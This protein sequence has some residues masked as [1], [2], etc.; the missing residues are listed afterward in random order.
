MLYCGCFRIRSRLSAFVF[1][2]W[3]QTFSMA[4]LTGTFRRRQVVLW[5][6]QVDCWRREQVSSAVFE[7]QCRLLKLDD[8]TAQRCLCPYNN[9]EY[10]VRMYNGASVLW[11]PDKA[12]F[13]VKKQERFH[14][15]FFD[16]PL[17]MDQQFNS[18][19]NDMSMQS[20]LSGKATVLLLSF[21]ITTQSPVWRDITIAV[22]PVRIGNG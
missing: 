19:F 20:S 5:E 2:C 21:V 1:E 17:R 4:T 22:S 7:Y 11:R 15:I 18:A 13:S 6:C 9:T 8:E 10:N 12:A 3:Q 14:L 16:Q